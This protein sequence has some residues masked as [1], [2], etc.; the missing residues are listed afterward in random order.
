[1]KPFDPDELPL[2]VAQ[3]RRSRQARRA[4]EFRRTQES[5]LVFGA[6]VPGVIASA[7]SCHINGLTV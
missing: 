7:A 2:R 5:D 1:M 4:D 3:V 6:D